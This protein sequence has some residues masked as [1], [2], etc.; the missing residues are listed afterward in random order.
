[1]G[2]YL[3]HFYLIVCLCFTYCFI[4][5]NRVW[6][7]DAAIGLVKPWNRFDEICR[8]TAFFFCVV[9]HCI[10]KSSLIQLISIYFVFFFYKNMKACHIGLFGFVASWFQTFMFGQALQRWTK[11]GN[12]LFLFLPNENW[13]D[14]VFLTWTDKSIQDSL[15]TVAWMDSERSHFPSAHVGWHGMAARYNRNG[16]LHVL[17]WLVARHICAIL[18]LFSSKHLN[19]EAIYR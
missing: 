12:Y 1:M 5:A 17:G 4:P 7:V 11:I 16:L 8:I 6:S 14:V 9:L 2:L 3:N 18:S 13:V 10:A 19:S 15:W